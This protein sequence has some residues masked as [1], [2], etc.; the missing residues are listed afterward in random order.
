MTV[1]MSGAM[2][3]FAACRRGRVLVAGLVTGALYG[4][5]TT[6]QVAPPRD[7]RTA[8]IERVATLDD[9]RPLTDA[10]RT[11]VKVFD[12]PGPAWGPGPRLR[13]GVNRSLVADE[14]NLFVAPTELLEP[15][16]MPTESQRIRNW[17]CLGTTAFGRLA[18]RR[19]L[20]TEGV[21]KLVTTYTL[22]IDTWLNPSQGAPQVIVGSGGGKVYVG[23]ELYIYEDRPLV[24]NE[25]MLFWLDP[26]GAG[27]FK[28][29]QTAR[30]TDGRLSIYSVEGTAADMVARAQVQGRSC[31]AQP[32]H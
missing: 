30:P 32:P 1:T 31:D 2:K 20:V 8:P 28:I 23:G 22:H 9:L 16:Q 27:A 11:L 19:V 15:G 6:A 12:V 25:A 10:E 13:P 18:P 14:G 4:V 24:T 3:R 21:D 7:P 17:V 29:E 26:A 5:S